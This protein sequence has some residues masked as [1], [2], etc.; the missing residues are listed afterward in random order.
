MAAWTDVDVIRPNQRR[1]ASWG[2]IAAVAIVAFTVGLLSVAAYMVFRMLFPPSLVEGAIRAP[3]ASDMEVVV[4]QLRRPEEVTGAILYTG[5]GQV[6]ET[7][8]PQQHTDRFAFLIPLRDPPVKL[9]VVHIGTGNG[10]RQRCV[11]PDD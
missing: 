6:Y 8:T 9:N 10:E 7:V 2:L 3:I 4:I 5:D 11:I 1:V